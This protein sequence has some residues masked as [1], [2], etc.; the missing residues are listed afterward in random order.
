MSF[1]PISILAYAFNAGSII[2]D[3]ILLQKSLPHP[4]AYAFYISILGLLAVILIPV[5][6]SLEP[7]NGVFYSA[8]SGIVFVGALYT[9]FAALKKAEASIVGP[10]VGALNPFFTI[11][12]GTIFFDQILD[13]NQITAILVLIFGAFVLTI[14]P[15]AQK[16]EFN[17]SFWLMVISGFLF[18]L[19]YIFLRE[20]F[21]VTT[22]I[23]GLII[24]RIS[25]GFFVLSFL[26][27][28]GLRKKIFERPAE[29]NHNTKTII[30]LLLVGQLLGAAQGLLITYAV[31]LANPALVNSLFGVQYVV[32]LAA[33]LFLYKK[34][35]DLLSETITKGVIIQKIIGVIILSGG[36]YL[37]AK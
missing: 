1:L 8:A 3:K 12:I 32:I 21:L 24:S 22:F 6:F 28:P 7:F 17:K 26:I 20:A 36:L 30:I 31:S 16:I 34:H 37:L 5:G 9:L 15:F 33:A 13:L 29:N 25:A 27:F 10:V 18:G 11:I 19:S 35:P 4:I 2:I 14:N 23:N